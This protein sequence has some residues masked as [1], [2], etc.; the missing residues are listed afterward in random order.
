MQQ[1]G[2]WNKNE[3]LLELSKLLEDNF[4][5][6]DGNGDVPSQIYSYLSTDYHDL[7]NKQ[8][9]DPALKA[10]GKDRWY[11]PDPNK[12]ADLE[13]KREKALLKEF[14]EY[15]QAK[16]KKLKVFRLESVRAGFKKAYQDRDYQTIIDIANKIPEDTLQEDQK[17]LMWYDQAMTRTGA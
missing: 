12:E 16:Q 10:S 7:K 3:Q 15:K 11:V 13:K 4:L 1:I 14:E 6:Y 9:D 8:K 5:K 2:G 17:L